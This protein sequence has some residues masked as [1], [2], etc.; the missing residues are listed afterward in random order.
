M[1]AGRRIGLR[2]GKNMNLAPSHLARPLFCRHHCDF[3]I[4]LHVAH[5]ADRWKLQPFPNLLTLYFTVTFGT[6]EVK[7]EFDSI[8][9]SVVCHLPFRAGING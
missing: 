2:H 3:R 8:V 9:D 6:F 1:V 4:Q 7:F 5:E